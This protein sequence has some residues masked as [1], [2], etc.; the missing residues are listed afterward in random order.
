MDVT[1]AVGIGSALGGAVFGSLG[2]AI[3]SIFVARRKVTFEARLALHELV[4]DFPA[5]REPFRS[6]IDTQPP[7][8]LKK[9][10]HTAMLARGRDRELVGILRGAWERYAEVIPDDDPRRAVLDP[11]TGQLIGR[12][13][14]AGVDRTAEAAALDAVTTVLRNHLETKIKRKLG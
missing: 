14:N 12:R 13:L 8:L 3:G 2:S 9:M 11:N 4:L 7:G 10:E 6:I 5:S 1:L